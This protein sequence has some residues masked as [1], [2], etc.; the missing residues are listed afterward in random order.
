MAITSV[1]VIQHGFVS[2]LFLIAQSLL[3]WYFVKRCES[4][5]FGRGTLL[6]SAK[7]LFA[8]KARKQSEKA[9]V[10]KAFLPV[11]NAVF[12]RIDRA[13][14]RVITFTASKCCK[15]VLQM[16]V[17]KIGYFLSTNDIPE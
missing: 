12:R 17:Y 2:A 1:K 9:L 8:S 3:V 14:F 16:Y 13:K 10:E 7:T 15:F 11:T 4:N 5:P 6:L